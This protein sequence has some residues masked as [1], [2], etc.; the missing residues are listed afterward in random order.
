[1][2]YI[3]VSGTGAHVGRCIPQGLLGYLGQ[4]NVPSNAVVIGVAHVESDDVCAAGAVE[5]IPC[6]RC[7][8]W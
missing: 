8:G 4:F 5:P 6:C 2:L 3:S 7:L 1:M